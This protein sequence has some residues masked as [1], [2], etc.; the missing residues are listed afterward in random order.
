MKTCDLCNILQFLE[1]FFDKIGARTPYSSVY[2]SAH[3]ALLDLTVKSKNKTHLLKN[4]QNLSHSPFEMKQLASNLVI[5]G[6]N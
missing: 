2:D 1:Y 4:Y 5:R 6:K 3:Y